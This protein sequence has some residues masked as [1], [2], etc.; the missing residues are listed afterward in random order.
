MRKDIQL[1]LLAL[2]G[3][4]AGF[5]LRLWQWKS[6]YHAE[7]QLFAPHAPATLALL[8]VLAMVAVLLLVM[9]RN[10]PAPGEFLPA[11]CSPS[12]GH[13]TMLVI[14][15]F[16]LLGGGL[17]GLLDGMDQLEY[18]RQM[19]QYTPGTVPLAP[20]LVRMGCS[21]LCLPAGLALLLVGKSTYR[22]TMPKAVFPLISLLGFAGL[23]WTLAIHLAHGVDP[24]LMR[25]GF[26]LLAAALLT[27]AHYYAA[28]F[29]FGRP[30]PRR[31]T[32]FALTGCVAAF[33]AL[34]DPPRPA[35]AMLLTGFALS[36]LA[37]STALLRNTFGPARPMPE[38]MPL[39]A[40][41]MDE[42]PT[43]E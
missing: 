8:G 29:L 12:A 27:L 7:T 43:E 20:V 34:A 39:G 35:D 16:L 40:E 28:G 22:L 17:L 9:V 33:T 30:C 14:A 11:F 24:V 19:N 23:L 38:R 32:F 18:W 6:V 13:M 41:D 26:L 25:Y 1:P 37:L 31:F 5:G 10:V 36:A 15:A 4:A 42:D 2:L 3:G 21:A